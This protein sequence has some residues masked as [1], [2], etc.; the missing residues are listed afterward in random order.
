MR[1]LAGNVG[2]T[3]AVSPPPSGQ[4]PA[5]VAVATSAA[6]IIQ[7]FQALREAVGTRR[8]VVIQLRAGR[9]GCRACG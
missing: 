5:Q 6:P 7:A 3:V 1:Q 2:Y 9:P 8:R 4:A